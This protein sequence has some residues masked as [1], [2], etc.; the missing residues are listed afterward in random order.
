MIIGINRSGFCQY[1]LAFV[2]AGLSASLFYLALERDSASLMVASLLTTLISIASY[3][4]SLMLLPAFV[5]YLILIILL[6]AGIPRGVNG[7]NL[8]IFFIPFL[9]SLFLLLSTSVRSYVYSGWGLNQLGRS[10][11]YIVFTLVYGLGIPIAVAAFLGGIHSIRYMSRGGLFLISYAVVPLL[12]VLIISPFLNI[13]GYYLFFTLPAYLLLAGLCASELVSAAPRGSK[14]L[15][16]A[17]IL[18]IVVALFA[19]DYLYFT[20]ENGGRPKWREALQTLKGKVEADSVVVISMPRIAEYYFGRPGD[21][22]TTNVSLMQLEDVINR[23]GDLENVWQWKKRRVWFVLD[24]LSLKSLDHDSRFRKWIYAN[25]RIIQRYPVYARVS[26]R[27]ITLWQLVQSAR[28]TDNE[29]HT[30]NELDYFTF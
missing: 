5:G 6:P 9:L 28:T 30:T 13:A 18:I 15:S 16:V 3:A 8:A 19:Q 21:S 12:I 25:C 11:I 24:E 7:K 17:V 29:T 4:Q 22:A 26:D 27:T 14:G 20:V 2:F 23:L 1:S 10:P